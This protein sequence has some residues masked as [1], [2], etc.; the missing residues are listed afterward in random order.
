M[1][2]ESIDT[3]FLWVLSKQLFDMCSSLSSFAINSVP[4]SGCSVLHGVNPNFKN[5]HNILDQ[6]CLFNNDKSGFMSDDTYTHQFTA[7]THTFIALNTNP[8]L[9]DCGIFQDISKAFDVVWHGSLPHK[10]KD[11]E[12]DNNLLSLIELFLH[13]RS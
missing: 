10:L 12:T 9:E 1:F 13:N 3:F 8:S 5:N 4:C 7:V 6:N 2:V 11:N